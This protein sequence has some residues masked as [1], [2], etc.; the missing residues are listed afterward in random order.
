MGKPPKWPADEAYTRLLAEHGESLARLAF[1][2][3]G[4]RPD[5][6]DVVQDA[7][8]SVA[9]RWQRSTLDSPLAYLRK[10]VARK[11]IDLSRRRKDVPSELALERGVE[12]AGYLRVEGDIAFVRLLQGLPE[13]QRSVLVF[14]YYEQLD[15]RTI[16]RIL[17]CRVVT[18]RSQASRALAKLRASTEHDSTQIRVGG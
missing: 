1:L 16:A 11:A 8:I 6:E 14:R 2:L 4:N 10:T 18:V 12:E 15:D 7:V 3:T 5:A 9:D 13:K 17:G